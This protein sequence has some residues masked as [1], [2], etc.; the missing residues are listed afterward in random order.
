MD[1]PS[2]DESLFPHWFRLPVR[3]RDLDPLNHVNNALFNTYY[4]EARIDFIREV[5]ALVRGLEEGF[6]FVLAEITIRYLHPAEFPDTLLIGTGI[7]DTGNSSISS[8]QAVFSGE[9]NRLLSTARATGVWFDVEAGRPAR[10]PDLPDPEAFRP[11]ERMLSY[12][13]HG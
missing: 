3:F 8:Y 10:L 2:Y 4:E 9:E 5:P 7:T 1:T 13:D 6:S 12:R 11:D